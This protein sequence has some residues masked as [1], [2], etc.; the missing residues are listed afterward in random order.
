MVLLCVYPAVG[1]SW[2]YHSLLFNSGY[3]HMVSLVVRYGSV[4]A[5]VTDVWLG[6]FV[7]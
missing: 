6:R 3:L 1:S 5:R 4:N 2:W 7:I